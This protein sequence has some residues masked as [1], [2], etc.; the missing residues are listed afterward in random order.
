MNFPKL[1]FAEE[2]TQVS[3]RALSLETSHRLFFMNFCKKELGKKR[4]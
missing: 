3:S 1:G 2:H 4:F